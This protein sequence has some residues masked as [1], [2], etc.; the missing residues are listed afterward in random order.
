MVA[1]DV[2]LKDVAREHAD[3]LK[4]IETGDLEAACRET[5][6]HQW[7]CADLPHDAHGRVRRDAS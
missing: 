6:E 2:T 7:H 1:A 4:T 5:R 3:L